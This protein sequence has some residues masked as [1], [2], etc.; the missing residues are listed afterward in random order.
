MCIVAFI[1]VIIMALKPDQKPS[2]VSTGKVD[3]HRRDNKGTLGNNS[4]LK[5]SKSSGTPSDSKN[6]IT[7]T[8]TT[9]PRPNGK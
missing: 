2:A 9:P 8:C 3:Q 1:G 5:P 4:R 7:Q 6:E